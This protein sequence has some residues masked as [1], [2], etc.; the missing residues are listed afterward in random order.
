M[1]E[2][3]QR[4]GIGTRALELL[5]DYLFAVWDL[6]AVFAEVPQY[7]ADPTRE[8]PTLNARLPFVL[9]GRRPDFHYLGGDYWDDM[10]FHLP[11][12]RW[13]AHRTGSP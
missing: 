6:R 4:Q 9:T 3:A 10:I 1:S 7:I 11:R 8:N 13:E 12:E 2:D 5:I